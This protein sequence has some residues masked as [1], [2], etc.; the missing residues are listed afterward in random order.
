MN[1][2]RITETPSPDES[3]AVTEF[4]NRH[5]TTIRN[6]IFCQLVKNPAFCRVAADIMR[7]AEEGNAS[8]GQLR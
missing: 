5:A 4:L 1:A 7:K 8:Q 6:W 3:A 2:P